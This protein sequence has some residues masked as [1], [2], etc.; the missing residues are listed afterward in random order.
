MASTTTAPSAIPN[1][2]MQHPSESHSVP[3]SSTPV[4]MS[5]LQSHADAQLSTIPASQPSSQDTASTSIPPQAHMSPAQASHLSDEP[6]FTTPPPTADGTSTSSPPQPKPAPLTRAETAAIGPSSDNP[7]VIPNPAGGPAVIITLLL[8]SSARHPYKIDEKYLKKR[9]VKADVDE[10]GVV[11]PFS[12]SVYTLKELIWRDWRD[13]WEQRPTSPSSIRLIHF[14]KML[15]DKSQ[16]R[17]CRFQAESANVVHMTIK[18]QEV[19]DD[20]DAKTGKGISRDRDN[21]R[22]P[23]CRCVIL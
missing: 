1:I 11:D 17:E 21:E 22:T 7:A 20:E 9:G 2:T 23:G 14:G 19:V 18:P 10:A 6:T 16:L 5:N 12:I 13:E 3:A 8:T 15:D 4:E